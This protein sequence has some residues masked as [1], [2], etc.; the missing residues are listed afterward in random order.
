MENKHSEEEMNL[1]ILDHLDNCTDYK[2]VCELKQTDAGKQR[3]I[4]RIKEL[5]FKDGITDAET[6]IAMVDNEIG[7]TKLEQ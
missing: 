5:I 1:I 7:W 4:T 3:I 2:N 6:A